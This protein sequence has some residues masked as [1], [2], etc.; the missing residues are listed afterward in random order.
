M[1][2]DCFRKFG[3]LYNI[4]FF[5]ELVPFVLISMWVVNDS[6]KTREYLMCAMLYVFLE[7]MIF[8][9]AKILIALYTDSMLAIYMGQYLWSMVFSF[10]LYSVAVRFSEQPI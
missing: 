3:T 2:T 9:F 10:Y 4:Y 5:F 1:E 6:R 8:H 7:R